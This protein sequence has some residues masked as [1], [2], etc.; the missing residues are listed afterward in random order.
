M[1]VWG[2]PM[3]RCD[4]HVHSWYS[5]KT[6]HVKLLEPMDSYSTPERIR[7]V[8]GARG[9]DFVT[10]T[11]HNSIAGCLAYREAHPD[12]PDFFISEEVTVPL[13]TFG[14]TL[15]VGVY[16]MA[17]GDHDEIRA[18]RGDLDSLL[19]YLDERGLFRVWNHPFY[20]FPRGARAAPLLR[21]LLERFPVCE[22][23]NSC[24]PPAVNQVFMDGVAA[25]ADGRGVTRLVA[26]SDAHSLARL[27]TTWTEAP[28]ATPAEFLSALR[29]GEGKVFG[30]TGRFTGVFGD[31]MGV[32]LGYLRDLLVRNE[33]HRDWNRWKKLRNSIGWALWL[34]V[35]TLGSFAYAVVQYRLFRHRLGEYRRVWSDLAPKE[36]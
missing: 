12:D 31:A 5:G 34:P 11:D 9:M 25:F 17:P 2:E 8:A 23:I 27:G 7:R 21:H 24:L 1:A 4:L 30:N 19:R 16:D 3:A 13:A 29:R 6:N 10:I 18:R 26:G 14:Y 33:V 36:S 20:G 32:Y 35:F 15:H 28:G 22:G